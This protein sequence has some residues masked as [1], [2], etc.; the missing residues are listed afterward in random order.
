MKIA[1]LFCGLG[2]GLCYAISF[3]VFKEEDKK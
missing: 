2:M 1:K 3:G